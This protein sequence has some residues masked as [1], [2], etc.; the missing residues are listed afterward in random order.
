[1]RVGGAVMMCLALA[2]PMAPAGPAAAASST[3]LLPDLRM[4][5]PAHVRLC[6]PPATTDPCPPPTVD[7][8]RLLRFSTIIFNKGHG[9]LRLVGTRAC[10]ECD[11]MTVEQEVLRSDGT[12]RVIPND[13]VMRFE[14]NDSHHH[15]HVLGMESY[16]LWGLGALAEEP[17]VSDK[18][19]FCFFDGLQ[20][21]PGVAGSPNWPAYG[22]EDCGG[23][24]SIRLEV[25]LSVGWGDI[26]PWYFHGQFIDIT[27]VSDG[28]YLLCVTADPEGVVKE[29]RDGNN[30][31]W[32]E[33]LISGD[34]V[35]VLARGNSQCA[36]QLP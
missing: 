11:T 19:G 5:R 31:A 22:I 9:P 34:T 12:I 30:E 16:K 24:D 6:A 23:P 13:G 36:D 17:A 18:Y 28:R 8:T 27:G 4:A 21:R 7:G 33:I 10:P 26:Y 14:T 1:M 20:H 3:P 15:W 35:R 32:A 25:G 2:L 29:R